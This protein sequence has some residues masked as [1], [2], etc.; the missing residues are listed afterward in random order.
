MKQVNRVT[1]EP[2]SRH[3]DKKPFMLSE[4]KCQA[5][6]G[7]GEGRQETHPINGVKPEKT[8]EPKATNGGLP[9]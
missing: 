3:Q 5:E 2:K 7:I 4:E 8:I 1:D 6:K 9:F